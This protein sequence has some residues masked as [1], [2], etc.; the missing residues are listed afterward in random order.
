MLDSPTPDS[1][2]PETWEG[3]T[4]PGTLARAADLWPD[5]ECAVDG[6]RRASYAELLVASQSL[7]GGLSELGLRRGDRLASWMGNG[8]DWL[9]VDFACGLLGV[10]LVPVNARLSAPEVAYVLDQSS[11]VA[12]VLDHALGSVD[13]L[14]AFESIAPR[15]PAL[16]HVIVRGEP[17]GNHLSSESLRTREPCVHERG[18]ADD[19]AYIIYT[20][21]TTSFP[22]GVMLSHRNVV[23]N[24]AHG[25]ERLR[26]EPDARL[27]LAPPLYSSYGCLTGKIGSITH[28]TCM[29]LLDRFSP[30]RALELMSEEGA[31]AFVGVDTM[32]RDMIGLVRSGAA[33]PPRALT[34]LTAFPMTPELATEARGTLNA[35][36]VFTGY[37]LTEASACSSWSAVAPDGSNLD[38]LEPMPRT[39][40]RVV[41]PDGEADVAV[42][43]EGELCV[44][45]PGVMQGYYDKL[46]ETAAVLRPGGWLRTGDLARRL[47]TAGTARFVGRLKDIIKTGGF[48]V[49]PLE[50]ERVLKLHPAVLEASDVGVPDD[51]LTEIGVAFVQ[52]D[53]GT[54]ATAEE[55]IAHCERQLAGFKVP[56]RIVFVDEFPMTG[57]QKIQKRILLEA[58]EAPATETG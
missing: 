52:L 56:R 48:N 38:I 18:N 12:L 37:G 3:L 9:A 27:L 23:R 13:L 33:P 32:V 58:L 50:V 41:E 1:I 57:S 22:K 47:D 10:T 49:S 4:V 21:G 44:R 2:H 26:F 40:F 55:L 54:T 30:K 51:R 16:R 42:G 31:T 28:R 15:L 17:T 7:A 6:A 45:S 36:T 39:E 29:L 53:D 14:S 11:A 46:E 35:A 20:S 5:A 19:L 24:S 34:G 43:E 8:I 25:A